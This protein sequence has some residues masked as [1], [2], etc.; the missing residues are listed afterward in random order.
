MKIQ[1]MTEFTFA[2]LDEMGQRIGMVV[3]RDELFYAGQTATPSVMDAATLIAKRRA[4]GRK[5]AR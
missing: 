2:V 5:G 1:Q 3:A 4:E